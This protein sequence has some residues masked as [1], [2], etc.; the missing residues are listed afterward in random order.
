M[1]DELKRLLYEESGITMPD[2]LF[3]RFIGATTE[4]VLKNRD[5]L[6]SAGKLDTNLYVQKSGLLHAWYFDGEKDKTYGFSGP[7][8]VLMSYH[9]QYFQQLPSLLQLE[10]CGESVVLKMPKSE[11]DKLLDSSHEFAKL[12][13]VLQTVQ[14]YFNEF[15][16][17]AINGSAKDRYL[18]L[19][20]KRPEIIAR[21]PHK[22][23]ASYLD[24]A[25]T[26]LSALKKI[27]LTGK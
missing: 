18:A 20:E 10:S 3:E 6:I 21:V 25:P 14:L 27:S 13:I 9:C 8:S 12:F 11:L 15:R 19:I 17:A 5:V 24:I 26:Y 22:I 7:G 23:I 16:H 2:E 1:D 4:V